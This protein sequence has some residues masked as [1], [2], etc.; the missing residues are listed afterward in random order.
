MIM[1]RIDRIKEIPGGKILSNPMT[2]RGLYMKT[3]WKIY[4][5]I[6]PFPNIIN[7]SNAKDFLIFKTRN[8]IKP[9]RIKQMPIKNSICD[10]DLP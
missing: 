4:A 8:S 5:A 9:N 1:D 6:A 10:A 2:V 7:V 3:K